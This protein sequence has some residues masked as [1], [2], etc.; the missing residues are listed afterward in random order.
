MKRILVIVALCS[1]TA[2][3]GQSADD[4]MSMYREMARPVAGHDKLK[5]LAGKWTVTT[6]AWFGPD[7]PPKTA[8]GTGTG[9]MILGDRFLQLDTSVKG[10]MGGDAMTVM[11]FDRR[12]DDYTMVGFDTLGTYFITAAGKAGEGGIVLAGTYLQPPTNREQKY[13]FVWTSPSAAEHQLT[14]YF[15]TPDGKEMLVAQT[16]LTRR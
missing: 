9:R 6:K 15:A 2:A 10:A 8:T 11:G 4:V 1:A 12:T 16:T 13:R 14:L 5:T 7:T 3:Y